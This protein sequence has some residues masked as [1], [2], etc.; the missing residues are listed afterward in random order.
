MPTLASDNA[1]SEFM[2]A[3]DEYIGQGKEKAEYQSIVKVYRRYQVAT[4]RQVRMV[5]LEIRA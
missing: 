4:T 1:V 5:I 3:T 2:L